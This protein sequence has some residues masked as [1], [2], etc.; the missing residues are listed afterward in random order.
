MN[1]IMRGQKQFGV[2]KILVILVRTTIDPER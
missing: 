1:I 2:S